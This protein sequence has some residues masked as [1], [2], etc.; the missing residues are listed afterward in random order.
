MAKLG[1]IQRIMG[2]MLIILSTTMLPPALISLIYRDGGLLPF[3]EA[4]AALLLLGGLIWLPVRSA[5]REL[6]V[7][8][9]FMLVALFWLVLG[10]ASAAPLVLAERPS[11]SLTEAVFEAVSGLTTTGA[12][13][14]S[15]LDSL[16]HSILWYRAQLHW[17]G[18]MGIIVLA[19]AILPMLGVGGMQLYRAEAPGPVKDS[20]LTPRIKQTAKALWFIY[21]GLTTACAL[22]YWL[23]GMTV[24]DAVTH[25][26][27][28][29]ATG[30][31]S[32]HDASMAHFQSPLIEWITIGFMILAGTN[33]SLHFLVWRSASLKTYLQDAEFRTYG[34]VL[35]T[36]SVV[37]TVYLLLVHEFDSVGTAVRTTVFQTVSVMTSTGYTTVN[38]SLWPSFVP[39]LLI[40]LSFMGGCGGS[41]AGGM[42]VIRFHLLFKQGMR[43]IV[44]LIHPNA[45]LPVKMG[46]RPVSDRVVEAVWGYFAAYVVL[47]VIMMLIL[48][49]T[50]LDQVTA[51]SAVATTLNNL[52][53]GL[54][55]VATTFASVSD[56]G[57]WVSVFAMLLGRLEIFTVLVLLT[58]AF[59]RH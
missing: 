51:F 3:L 58:P 49:G 14:L 1:Y 11:L 17:L 21:L 44:R 46:R 55:E 26:F 52:G 41:T 15:G 12:T 33:F 9:G 39:A 31:F 5:Q 32:T 7:R 20:K 19:V 59:W 28:T 10:L 56:L 29:L 13:V 42:K 30:G 34:T 50:G 48:M 47:F 4:F 2:L 43:E 53:P 24:F 8:D 38:F 27:S 45:E 36:A 6:R 22:A 57:K 40:F 16:P 18:G 37:I 25:A 23:A 35:F 54:G